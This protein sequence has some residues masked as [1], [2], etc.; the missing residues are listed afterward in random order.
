MNSMEGG[1]DKQDGLRL[2][3][4]EDRPE[5]REE[6]SVK[7]DMA[8][9][10]GNGYAGGYDYNQDYGNTD[11]YWYSPYPPPQYP[12]PAYT[13]Y[14]YGMG[15][16]YMGAFAF[17]KDEIHREDTGVV[18][19]DKGMKDNT[20]KCKRWTPLLATIKR[21][22][23]S[24]YEKVR[25]EGLMDSGAFD[26]IGP[27]GLMGGNEIRQT[28][29]S[30]RAAKYHSV[31]GGEITNI[32]EGDLMGVSEEGVPIELTAQI[33]DKVK[34]LLIAIRRIVEEGN[35]VIFGANMEGIKK[36][37]SL[38]RIEKHLIVSKSGIRS[39]IKEKGGMYVYPMIITRK[40]NNAED[41][42]MASA[43][44]EEEE[45]EYDEWAPF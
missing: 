7:E 11:E 16:P 27:K 15:N 12:P 17:S 26:T 30:K 39:E 14:M 10:E 36:L 21:Q 35:M 24:E 25:V 38:E 28:A 32:G 42:H 1:E 13:P 37:A 23:E 29:A 40:K 2:G 19:K 45:D 33:G 5:P 8:K 9:A 6:P 4:G 18:I 31:D 20:K 34:R 3:G 22:E 44:A 41:A 43:E